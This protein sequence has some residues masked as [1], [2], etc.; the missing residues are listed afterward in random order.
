VSY[1]VGPAFFKAAAGGGS[2][3]VTLERA[4]IYV[5]S[6][7]GGSHTISL[8]AEAPV[9][10]RIGLSFKF[11]PSRTSGMT[12]VDTN[13]SALTQVQSALAQQFE[14]WYI[15]D[16]EVTASGVT[17]IVVD[18]AGN[19]G[20]DV[21]AW[22][23]D[24]VDHSSPHGDIT[25]SPATYT[26]DG[27]ARDF[28]LTTGTTDGFPIFMINCNQTYTLN[29][30]YAGTALTAGFRGVYPNTATGAAGVKTITVTPSASTSM[31]AIGVAY[32][33]A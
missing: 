30:G 7:F 29:S 14:D 18:P 26:F 9:G 1:V 12:V 23:L 15:F 24:G 8:G 33:A 5:Q 19:G 28:S 6:G 2:S 4:M 13:G 32:N 31:Q 17:S 27:A 3:G 20:L 11:D 10:T 22:V 21:V 25:V 16:K